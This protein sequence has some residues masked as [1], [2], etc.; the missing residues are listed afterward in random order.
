MAYTLRGRLESR[1]AVV[2][3]PLLAACVV[4]LAVEA[5]WPV[6]LAGLMLGVG[7]VFDLGVYHR[8]LPYQP[9]WA[10]LP[11]GL[12]ELAAVMGL[13]RLLNV[14]AGLAAALAFY[15]G[16]WL[17]AQIMGHAVLPLVRLS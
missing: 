7:V 1:L 6:E 14:G 8:L 12:V 16:A 11:L 4:A 13:G 17:L 3:G 15:V 2:L 5:W 9:G 10:A